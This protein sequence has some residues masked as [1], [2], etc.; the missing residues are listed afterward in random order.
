MRYRDAA[1][2]LSGLGCRIVLRFGKGSHRVWE[3]PS[4]GRLATLPDWGSNDLKN[5]TLRAAV[6]QLGLMGEEFINA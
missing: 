1:R 2:K 5:G 4:S 6:K 3:N